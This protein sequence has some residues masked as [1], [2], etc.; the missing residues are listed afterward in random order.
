MFTANLSPAN[1]YLSKADG[2]LDYLTCFIHDFL[3]TTSVN[4][5]TLPH[6]KKDDEQQQP[7]DVL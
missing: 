1:E 5:T 3:N 6:L 4:K 7:A 2:G